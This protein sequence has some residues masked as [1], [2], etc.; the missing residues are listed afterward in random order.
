[1]LDWVPIEKISAAS[2]GPDDSEFEKSVIESVKKEGFYNPITTNV[3][4]R[5]YRYDPS[6]H[7]LS[8]GN[9]RY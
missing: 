6:I 9:H 1:M 8:L 7:Y 4:E 2:S 5:S 3:R